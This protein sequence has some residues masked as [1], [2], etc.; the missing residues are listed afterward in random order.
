MNPQCLLRIYHL[1]PKGSTV[2][3]FGKPDQ[4]IRRDLLISA[5]KWA[6]VG[7]SDM[8]ASSLLDVVMRFTYATHELNPRYGWSKG[9]D[10]DLREEIKILGLEAELSKEEKSLMEIIAQTVDG[11]YY[12]K[13]GHR[14]RNTRDEGDSMSLLQTKA[15]L[16]ERRGCPGAMWR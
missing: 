9:G 2:L 8:T 12:W 14:D 5:L 6:S 13:R 11:D 1:L 3:A 16:D 10:I 7:N 4:S 15:I